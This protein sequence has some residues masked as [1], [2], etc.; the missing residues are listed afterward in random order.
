MSEK[1][2]A[3]SL[4]ENVKQDIRDRILSAGVPLKQEELATQYG[5]S[6]IP[7][8]DVLQKL[9]NEGWLVSCGKRGVMI[10]ELSAQEATDL[11]LMREYLEP[12]ILGFAIPQLTHS[13]LGQ[14]ADILE[15]LDNPHLSVAEYGELNWQ[16]HACLYRAAQRPTLFNTI[17]GLHQLCSRYIGF[18]AVELKYDSTSQTEHHQLLEAIKAKQTSL[19]QSILKSHIRHASQLLVDFLT[20]ANTE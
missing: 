3:Q 6:R 20:Q 12:L 14:A 4:Y 1:R 16:F 13:Q 11:S 9:K 10:P 2:P 5:V 18:H 17:A 15:Q 19:A 8:R 7:V